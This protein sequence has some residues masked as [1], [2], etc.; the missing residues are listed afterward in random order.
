MYCK[1]CGCQLPDEAQFCWK[2]GR[3]QKDGIQVHDSRESCEIHWEVVQNKGLFHS[4]KIKF[5]AKAYSPGGIY[6]A[7]ESPIFNAS[8]YYDCPPGSSDDPGL[9]QAKNALSHLIDQ[10]LKNR[11]EYVGTYGEGNYWEKHFRRLVT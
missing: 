5:F 6:R 11:W 3:P 4:G 7:G 10:L 9:V 1:Y 2:C 8:K